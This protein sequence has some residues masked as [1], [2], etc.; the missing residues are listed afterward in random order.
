MQRDRRRD[1]YP[2]TWELPAMA[3][4]LLLLVVA[5]GFQL[6]RAAANLVAGAGWTWPDAGDG[7]NA[8]PIGAAFWTS[9]PGVLGGNASAGLATP[10]TVGLASNGLLWTCVG[11]T[12]L[13]LVAAIGWGGIHAHHRWGPG[14]M[15]GMA[16]SVEAERLLGVTRL[17]QLA[18]IVRP[19]LY[20]GHATQVDS[21]HGPGTAAP[22]SPGPRTTH[23]R[24]PWLADRRTPPG[25]Q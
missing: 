6:G 24:S 19:D 25:D 8:S 21:G 17:R 20:G 18:D 15:R 10:T 14:R 9:M 12:E 4:A 1:P 5:S 3:V 22:E 11:L 13:C 2:W 23:T 16:T 7:A